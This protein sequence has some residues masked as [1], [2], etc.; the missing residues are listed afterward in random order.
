LADV[1]VNGYGW[2]NFSISLASFGNQNFPF[3]IVRWRKMPVVEVNTNDLMHVQ[4]QPHLNKPPGAINTRD[5][6]A[7][8]HQVGGLMKHMVYT[9]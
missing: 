9:P 6:L 5:L 7:G 8:V 3:L 2:G 1:M 4:L